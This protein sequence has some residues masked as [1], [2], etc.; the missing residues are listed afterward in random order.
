MMKMVRQSA[1]KILTDLRNSADFDRPVYPVI[2]TP[3]QTMAL[4]AAIDALQPWTPC[5][6]KNPEEVGFYMCTTVYKEFGYSVR[7]LYFAYCLKYKIDGE[8]IC[9]PT[10]EPI[11]PRHPDSCDGKLYWFYGEDFVLLNTEEEKV[12]AWMPFPE[13]YKEEECT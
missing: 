12:I 9:E 2:S 11:A 3:E 8:E 4:D 1:I 10:C 5:K 6:E 7:P 13:P